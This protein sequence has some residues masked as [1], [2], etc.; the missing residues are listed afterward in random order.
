MFVVG[1]YG[2]S[3]CVL[4]AV[5]NGSGGFVVRFPL[6]KKVGVGEDGPKLVCYLLI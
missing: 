5:R 2:G 3:T 6:G 1:I 4:F